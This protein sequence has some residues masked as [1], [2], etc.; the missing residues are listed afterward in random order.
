MANE[1]KTKTVEKYLESFVGA[2]VPDRTEKYVSQVANVL[3]AIAYKILN[4][5]K[6]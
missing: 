3:L 6:M 5:P 1:V 2:D 4:I